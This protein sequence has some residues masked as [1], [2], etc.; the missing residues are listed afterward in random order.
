MTEKTDGCLFISDLDGTLLGSDARLSEESVRCLNDAIDAGA[1]FSIATARTPATVDVLLENVGTRLPGVVMTGAAWWHFDSKT[2]SHIHYFENEA[3]GRILYAFKKADVTPFVYVL[4]ENCSKHILDVY[5]NN[6][7]MSPADSSF[8]LQRSRLPL[9][10]F[11]I[12]DSLPVDA[13]G[14]VMLFYASGP[15]ERLAL[16]REKVL[17]L[18]DFSVS[19]YDDIY[20][21]GVALIE[22]FAPGVSK[23]AAIKEMCRYYG[24]TSVVAFGD[25]LND[26][27]MF[28]VAD[29]SVAVGNASPV[30]RQEADIVIGDNTRSSVA[31]FILEKVRKLS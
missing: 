20:N 11:H 15:M 9:K 14:S 13:S 31:R 17:R 27:P 5:Y 12:G 23:A 22:I 18:A 21:P 1:N 8:Y 30:V 6:V 4:R 25:N 19:L 29:V 2:Y 7:Y 16:V 26:L 28:S 24:F 3:V 10:K